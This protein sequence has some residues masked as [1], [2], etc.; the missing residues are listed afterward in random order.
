M[1]NKYFLIL[2]VI[3]LFQF[4]KLNAQ[5]FGPDVKTFPR[6]TLNEQQ[7]TMDVA[8][9][10]WIY[11]AFAINNGYVL[12]MSKDNGNTWIK[13]DSQ[14][15]SGSEFTVHLV[16]AGIDT[17]YLRVYMAV[18]KSDNST[19]DAWLSV[20]V[21]D[22][23]HGTYIST[24]PLDYNP[25]STTRGFDIATDYKFPSS[26]SSPYSIGILYAKGSGQDSLLLIVSTD[27]GANYNSRQVVAT[28]GTFFRKVSLAYG[29]SGTWTY[30]R[31]FMA[32]EHCSTPDSIAASLYTA[33]TPGS[34][35]D[36]PTTPL[37]LDS[38]FPSF[39]NQVCNPK[40]VTSQTTSTDND[41]GN[42]TALIVV[43]R[44]SPGDNANSI[45]GFQ[46]FSAVNGTYWYGGQIAGFG[47]NTIE[48]DAVFE[49]GNSAFYV[50]YYNTSTNQL[51]CIQN[52][53]NLNY[54]G[55]WNFVTNNYVD[56]TTKLE[57]PWPTVR[58]NSS[59]LRTMWGWTNTYSGVQQAMF[60]AEY[61]VP[62]PVIISL[63]PD[64]VIAG[65]DSFT[66][67]ING[68]NF[69]SSSYVIWNADTLTIIDGGSTQVMVAIPAN[70]VTAPGIAHITVVTPDN[71]GGGG[72]SNT[73]PFYVVLAS[74]INNLSDAGALLVYP[75]PA[76][77][78]FNLMLTGAEYGGAQLLVS[79]IYGRA[80][81]KYELR[82]G[83]NTLG[84]STYAPGSYFL[85]AINGDG[86]LI[87]QSRITVI[88]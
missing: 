26:V 77:D 27:S 60:D 28:T 47:E 4:S 62:V 6:Q 52:S 66:L 84:V 17:N 63:A 56:D 36:A 64:T 2:M 86:S 57:N 53:I 16:V 88:R 38:L 41:S 1:K 72:P 10:G 51:P 71:L 14:V 46:N 23:T 11:Q 68:A 7:V 54:I 80:I 32:W 13:I 50:T 40:I 67:T 76:K 25:I 34:L 79:D 69:Y 75:N 9:N 55:G 3:A 83:A 48:P 73:L 70:M 45:V 18:N 21:Y 44:V 20:N 82:A 35:T 65:S 8:V 49:S 81:R 24:Q 78:N 74:G 59:F 43:E 42:I 30:G 39:L 58:V 22:G 37:N 87:G 19:S 33:Y 15:V 31:F 61:R 85:Q 29:I 12:V 5:T